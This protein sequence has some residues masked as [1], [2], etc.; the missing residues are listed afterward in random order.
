MYSLVIDND[1]R[2]LAPD[3]SSNDL[4]E[5]ILHLHHEVAVVIHNWDMLCH[6]KLPTP[7]LCEKGSNATGCIKNVMDIYDVRCLY[8]RP[9]ATGKSQT[10]KGEWNLN[11]ALDHVVRVDPD[12]CIALPRLFS[13][14]R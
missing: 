3:P 5:N 14:Q 10:D 1:G 4:V 8:L 11:V 7:H 2:C 6:E 9:K 12:H 13:R